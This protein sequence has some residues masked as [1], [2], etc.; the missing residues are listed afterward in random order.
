MVLVGV[1][2]AVDEEFGWMCTG[3]VNFGIKLSWGLEMLR[4]GVK[5]TI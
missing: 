1:F 3:M 5:E 4:K 2:G